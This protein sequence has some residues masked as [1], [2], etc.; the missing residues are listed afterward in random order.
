MK[1][2]KAPLRALFN[3]K[4]SGYLEGVLEFRTFGAIICNGILMEPGRH[5]S[6]AETILE[7]YPG[8]DS[9]GIE[10]LRQI[11]SPEAED[12]QFEPLPEPQQ[13]EDPEFARFAAW[14]QQM[15]LIDPTFNRETVPQEDDA[16]GEDE[17]QDEMYDYGDVDKPMLIDLEDDLIEDYPE[18]EPEPEAEPPQ[19]PEEEEK[20]PAEPQP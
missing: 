20:D 16:E 18:P 2:I 9:C 6:D 15:G 13:C 1:Q 7:L 8:S 11:A 5:K 19:E 14:A 4:E 3:L 10:I 17:Y 12:G